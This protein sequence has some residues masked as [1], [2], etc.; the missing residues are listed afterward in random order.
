MYLEKRYRFSTGLDLRT[1]EGMHPLDVRP[2]AGIEIGKSGPHPHHPSRC[3]AVIMASH[4]WREASNPCRFRL[5]VRV[6]P[7]HRELGRG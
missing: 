7:M 1:D 3:C 2:F 5:G 4:G 6:R